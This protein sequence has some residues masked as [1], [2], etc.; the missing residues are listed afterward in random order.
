MR[1]KALSGLLTKFAQDKKILIVDDFSKI[2][3]KTK[4]AI[5]LITGLKANDEVLSK[6]RKIGI[7]T[8]KAIVPLKRAFGNLKDVNLF[9]SK[10]LNTYDLS[11]QNYL[12]FSQTAVDQLK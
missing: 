7:I 9:S 3:P 12:I 10:S 5:K 2:E 11:K 8:D 6:S 4:T 1:K